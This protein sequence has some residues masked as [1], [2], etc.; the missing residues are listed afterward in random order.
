MGEGLSWTSIARRSKTRRLS[1]FFTICRASCNCWFI[2]FIFEWCIF[3]CCY[4]S[5]L[6]RW[7][8]WTRR[9]TVKTTRVKNNTFTVILVREV[10]PSTHLARCFACCECCFFNENSFNTWIAWNSATS[11]ITRAIMEQAVWNPNVVL[12]GNKWIRS[13]VVFVGIFMKIVTSFGKYV[14]KLRVLW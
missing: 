14:W 12:A 1:F 7:H 11:R 6:S 8:F 2:N 13:C 3:F 4:R 9:W 10:N 5:K